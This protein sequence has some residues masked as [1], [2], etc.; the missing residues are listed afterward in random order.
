MAM[1]TVG[2]P[3]VEG[4][5]PTKRDN[6]RGVWGTVRHYTR[7]AAKAMAENKVCTALTASFIGLCISAVVTGSAILTG[8]ATV[9]AVIA[10]AAL[11]HSRN[12]GQQT[13]EVAESVEG[14]VEGTN[15]A[16][17]SVY[18]GKIDQYKSYSS[19]GL[20]GQMPLETTPAEL[21]GETETE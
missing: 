10:I 11:L 8:G 16:L 6:K 12:S 3:I 5:T 19:Q 18:Q 15:E 20:K 13:V 14:K 17:Q 7:K 1:N 21:T 9:V 4:Y 2:A